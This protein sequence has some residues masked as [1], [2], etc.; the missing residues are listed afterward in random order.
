MSGVEFQW[1]RPMWLL[2]LIPLALLAAYWLTRQA[3]QSAWE[4]M[5]DPH[6]R[7]YVI[8]DASVRKR[9]GPLGLFAG[10]ALG[11]ILLA[12]PVWEQ[13]EVPVFQAQKAEVILLDLS[14]SMLAD[15]IA[16]DRMTRARFKL[17]DLLAASTGRQIGLI[18]FAERP[19]VIAP[20]T[21][22]TATI[23]AFL[24]SLNTNI[25]PAQGSRLDLAIER[26]VEL[27]Q[28]ARV[29]EG[30]ILYIGDQ[31]VD[32][33]D[34]EAAAQVQRQG[35]RLSVLA[36]GTAS[37]R[38]L[39]DESGQFL[40]D[41]NGAIVVPQVSM[42]DMRALADSGAGIAVRLTTDERDLALLQSVREDLLIESDSS[43]EAGSQNYWVEHSA[44]LVWLLV[45]TSLLLF[46]RGV[47][48]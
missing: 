12:G 41:A 43:E 13:Q 21:E 47:L 5:V 27:L 39:R 8:D 44:W 42:Q 9:K 4:N 20:L 29:R 25:V 34:L 32:A 19:Y 36:V 40:K 24:P 38:P 18:G 1:L 14:R 15:D 48:A 23:E 46:R 10:W 7:A 30:H 31:E 22:D 2:G 6:L 26:A 35:H 33:R 16:P 37:G 3:R 11:I 28:Q 17:A 45:F